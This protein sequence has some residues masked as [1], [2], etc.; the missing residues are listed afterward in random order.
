MGSV[1]SLSLKKKKKKESYGDAPNHTDERRVAL[2][3]GGGEVNVTPPLLVFCIAQ[4][5]LPGS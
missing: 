1:G 2:S 3:V 5:K 4:I